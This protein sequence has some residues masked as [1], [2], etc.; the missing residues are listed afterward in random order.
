MNKQ[1]NKFNQIFKKIVFWFWIFFFSLS[2]VSLILYLVLWRNFV[3][4]IIG[5]A[6][7]LVLAIIAFFIYKIV[8]T[9]IK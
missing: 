4:F 2:F 3:V 7:N 1:L 9:K 8:F 5:V 6:M